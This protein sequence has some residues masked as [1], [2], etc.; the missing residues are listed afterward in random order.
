MPIGL[1]WFFSPPADDISL[2]FSFTVLI[3]HLT[4]FSHSFQTVLVI[5]TFTSL[6]YFS[7]HLFTNN[8]STCISFFFWLMSVSDSRSLF[9]RRS[10]LPLRTQAVGGTSSEYWGVQR[11]CGH[12]LGKSNWMAGIFGTA[13]KPEL[14]LSAN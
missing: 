7:V 13:E 6:L 3:F 4:I 12:N 8:V 9:R 5:S 2:L 11:R 1:S 10:R 14:F